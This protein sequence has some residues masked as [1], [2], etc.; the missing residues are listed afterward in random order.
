MAI[1]YNEDSD[2]IYA[3]QQSSKKTPS[4]LASIANSLFTTFE[5]VHHIWPSR[6]IE[7]MSSVLSTEDSNKSKNEVIIEFI[8]ELKEIV[9]KFLSGRQPIYKEASSVMHLV[10]F[11]YSKLENKSQNFTTCCEHVVTWLDELAKER[12]IEETTMTRDIIALLIQSSA[13]IGE[14]DIIYG[15]CQDIHLF[16]GDLEVPREDSQ[17]ELNVNYQIVNLKTFA[18]ITSKVFEFLDASFDDL[19]WCIGRLKLC[20][21]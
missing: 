16:T 14:F 10:A 17:L 13:S 6:S 19:T 21:T 20:G 4:V 5:L 11:L 18:V 7:L 2:S 3:N 12:P 8:M 9:L 1:L 15:L